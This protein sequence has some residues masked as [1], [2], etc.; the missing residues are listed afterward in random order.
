MLIPKEIAEKAERF[1]K[2]KKELDALF[3]ELEEWANENGFEDTL[4][5]GFGRSQE[6]EGEEQTDGEYCDQT[7]RG[8]DSGSGIY[9]YPIEG[10]TE[11]MWVEY[12]F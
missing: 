1:E 10:S 8:E 3:E 12:E 2:I 6:P 5:C 11:Y 9:Y 4:I 7:M